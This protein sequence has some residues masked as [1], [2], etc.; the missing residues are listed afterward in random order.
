VAPSAKAPEKDKNH[1]FRSI[2][3]TTA[4]GVKSTL[5]YYIFYLNPCT[6]FPVLVFSSACKTGKNTMIIRKNAV[7][8]GERKND[9][10]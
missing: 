3:Q 9:G 2:W 1:E 4:E 5:I 7:L 10:N 8:S 6:T